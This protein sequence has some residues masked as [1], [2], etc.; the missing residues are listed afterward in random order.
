MAGSRTQGMVGEKGNEKAC[1]GTPRT[2]S[3]FQMS[4]MEASGKKERGMFGGE[5]IA[6]KK[7]V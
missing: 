6:E 1:N 5:Y 7:V 4:A 2:G 3:S